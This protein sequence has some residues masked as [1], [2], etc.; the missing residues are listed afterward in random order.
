MKQF[1]SLNIDL[2]GINFN[3]KFPKGE[4]G[5]KMLLVLYSN[6]MRY[7]GKMEDNLKVDLIMRGFDQ[8]FFSEDYYKLKSQF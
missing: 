8:G 3:Q 5:K 7:S 4:S 2:D 1:E 6:I